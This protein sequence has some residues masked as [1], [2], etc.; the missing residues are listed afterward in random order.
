MRFQF[1]RR[2]VADLVKEI[3]ILSV[4]MDDLVLVKVPRHVTDPETLKHCADIFRQALKGKGADVLV[5]ADGTDV[6]LVRAKETT[7][8]GYV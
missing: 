7:P 4:A 1:K 8:E 6:S 3:Q 5:V 2:S